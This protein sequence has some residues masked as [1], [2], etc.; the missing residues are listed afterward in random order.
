MSTTTTGRRT[1]LRTVGAPA[2]LRLV[3]DVRS[4]TTARDD[5]AHV[6][7]E[8]TD[9]RGRLVPD[10]T[11]QV[12]FAIT[13]AGQL[14]GVANGN[15]HNVDSFRQ[16]RRHTWHGQALAVLR[17]GKQPGHITLTATAPGLRPATLTLPVKNGKSE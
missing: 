1:T 12:G 7:V 4:L 11:L 5:L 6:L 2:A 10:A 17:P 16:P 8:V 15:P 3:S 14:A 13:G 9:A